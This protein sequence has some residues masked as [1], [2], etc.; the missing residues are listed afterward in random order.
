[1]ENL[2]NNALS[3]RALIERI[4]CGV[5]LAP[6]PAKAHDA[7]VLL[8]AGRF[9]TEA[10]RIID[11]ARALA[12]ASAA[13]TGVRGVMCGDGPESDTVSRLL[14]DLPGGER[15]KLLGAI[16]P[17][18]V[19]REMLTAS[20]VVLLS[21][22]EGLPIALMEG[23]ACGLVPIVTEMRSGISELV[24]H[25]VNGLVV[26]DRGPGFV[27]AVR[28]LRDDPAL[29]QRLGAAARRTIEE[30]YSDQIGHDHW[31]D[32]IV[33]LRS[34]VSSDLRKFKAPETFSLP[35]IVGALGREDWR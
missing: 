16:D 2:A 1:V 5:P 22:Y 19:R 9:V 35:P 14:N 26:P 31:R 27:A 4:P 29:R 7:L 17:D 15:V 24:R 3:G 25:E 10:K 6:I 18:E 13:L 11:V 12:A 28:R 20:C 32:L 8:Y 30:A 23:M 21:D 34:S 33:R